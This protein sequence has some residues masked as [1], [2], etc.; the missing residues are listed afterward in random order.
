MYACTIHIFMPRPSQR[1]YEYKYIQ[2]KRSRFDVY[3]AQH[4]TS[5]EVALF[6]FFNPRAIATLISLSCATKPSPKSRDTYCILMSG[7]MVDDMVQLGIV[8][9]YDTVQKWA[10]RK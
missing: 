9:K 1:T 8:T 6:S 7:N 3:N 4:D 2:V 5:S 10:A